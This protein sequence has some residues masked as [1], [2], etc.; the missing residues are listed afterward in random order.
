MDDPVV[1]K[2][3]REQIRPM[4]DRLVAAHDMVRSVTE[5]YDAKG[6]QALLANENIGD[7]VNDGPFTDGRVPLSVGGLLLMVTNAKTLLAQLSAVDQQ[8]GLSMVQGVR[9]IAVN[10][11]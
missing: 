7:Q 5:D 10:P 9:A 11:R 8:T 4:C 2:F 3:V 1:V 6:I